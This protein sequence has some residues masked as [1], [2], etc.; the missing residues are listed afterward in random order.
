MKAI[1][2]LD[3]K[4]FLND[5]PEHFPVGYIVEGYCEDSEQNILILHSENEEPL[6]LHNEESYSAIVLE[7]FRDF[8][9][10]F[11][12]HLDYFNDNPHHLIN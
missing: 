6:H 7:Y 10:K 4:D 12:E 9:K 11:M 5:I 3:E 1:Y 2:S 8:D